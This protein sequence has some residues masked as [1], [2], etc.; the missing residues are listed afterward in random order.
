MGLYA[1]KRALLTPYIL[2]MR[3]RER[4]QPPIVRSVL[5]TLRYSPAIY[6]FMRDGIG[7][8][9]LSEAPLDADSVVVDVGAY[10]GVWAE[11]IAE[12]YGMHLYAFE[13]NPDMIPHARSRL[14]R[15]EKATLY[16][17]ALGGAD[18]TATL[19]LRGMGTTLFAGSGDEP[20]GGNER[21]VTVEVRDIKRVLDEIGIDDIDFVK[22]NIEGGEFDLLD[23]L[24][25][26]GDVSR[27]RIIQ[28]QFHEWHRAAYSRRRKIQKALRRTH[29][30]DWDYPFVWERW[31]R[32]G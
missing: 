2:V 16:P 9:F 21:T 30:Q 5:E 14:A 31:S 23:R 12:R 3:W 26:T 10:D 11:E 29:E 22:I 32:R 25:E 6:R 17:Y 19:T 15:F 18:A 7:N 28:V 13:P 4:N 20:P 8:N 1:I 24:I 27:F